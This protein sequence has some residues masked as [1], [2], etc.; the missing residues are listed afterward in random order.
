MPDDKPNIAQYVPGDRN[1]VTGTGDIKYYAGL[2]PEQ[3]T[4]LVKQFTDTESRLY[5]GLCPYVGLRAFTEHDADVGL[6]YGRKTLTEE[7]VRRVNQSR[8]VILAGP[9]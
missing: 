7:L 8:F 6:F 9:S 5:D 1:F 3:V 2:T 4:E